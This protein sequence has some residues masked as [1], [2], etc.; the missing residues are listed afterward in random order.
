MPEA[1]T[2]ISLMEEPGMLDYQ[3][4]TDCSVISQPDPLL[5]HNFVPGPAVASGS[6]TIGAVCAPLHPSPCLFFSPAL[7]SPFSDWKKK[8]GAEKKY[9]GKC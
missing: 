6:R 4:Q 3:I 2:V 9:G 8:R 5:C 1:T 7:L